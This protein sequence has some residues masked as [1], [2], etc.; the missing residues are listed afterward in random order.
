[1]EDTLEYAG[2]IFATIF[3]AP[4]LHEGSH[5]V[6]VWMGGGKPKFYYVIWKFVPNRVK[7]R[8]LETLSP[9]IIRAS[10]IAPLIWMPIGIIAW[11]FFLIE[12]TP[13]YFL[14]ALL[15]T[16]TLLMTTK[17]DAMAFRDPEAFRSKALNNDLERDPLFIPNSW[18]PARLPRI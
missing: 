3:I 12:L 6:V 17:P 14:M 11:G 9:E 10:G 8:E 1:M 13:L 4:Y 2:T 5:W 15:P 16:G 7:I 18:I